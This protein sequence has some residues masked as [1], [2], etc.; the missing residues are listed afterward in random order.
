MVFYI[1]TCVIK[2]L[3]EKV[4]LLICVAFFLLTNKV[5]AQTNIDTIDIRIQ[6]PETYLSAYVSALYVESSDT[7]E[8]NLTSLSGYSFKWSGDSAPLIDT[9]PYAVYNFVEDGTYNIDLTVL[10]KSTSTNFT[11]SRTI[12]LTKPALIKVPNVFSPNGDNVNDLFTVFYDGVTVL[13]FTIF[14]RTGIQ[15]IKIKSPT[16]VW[17]GRNSSGSIMS[18]GVYYYILTSDDPNIDAQT[19]FIHLFNPQKDN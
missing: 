5:I 6:F 7:S 11:F 18:E 8:F 9:L 4:K 3:M 19:G 1:F 15:V 10:E 16:I 17:D 14:S 2:Y 12:N 13:E